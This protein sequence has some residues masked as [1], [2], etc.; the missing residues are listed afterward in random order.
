[1]RKTKYYAIYKGDIFLYL[2]TRKECA[3]YLD[4]GLKTI[5]FYTTPT[6]RKRLKNNY[7]N[8]TIVIRVKD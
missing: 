5:T 7:D 4:V 3:D 1:M 2:G 6:Y 8:Q